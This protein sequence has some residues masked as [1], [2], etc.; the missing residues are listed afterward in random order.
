MKITQAVQREVDIYAGS[1]CGFPYYDKSVLRM[2]L[3][4]EGDES[5]TDLFTEGELE[6]GKDIGRK[7]TRIKS[8]EPTSSLLHTAEVASAAGLYAGRALLLIEDALIHKTRLADP[9][10]KTTKGYTVF[11]LDSFSLAT[12]ERQ[13]DE[14]RGAYTGPIIHGFKP[15]QEGQPPARSKPVYGMNQITHID[16]EIVRLFDENFRKVLDDTHQSEREVELAYLGSRPELLMGQKLY[17]DREHALKNSG[18]AIYH[19]PRHSINVLTPIQV[20]G[21]FLPVL[22]FAHAS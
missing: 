15:F 11:Q 2:A 18:R 17:G 16:H 12:A 5:F 3:M 1:S 7:N 21:E 9:S 4:G 22:H 19:K 10:E 6:E 14:V 8:I 20:G 13:V